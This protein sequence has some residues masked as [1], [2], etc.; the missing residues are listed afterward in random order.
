M[1]SIVIPALNEEH[2]IGA[3]IESLRK[4]LF[5]AGF[6][7]AEILVVDD[8]SSDQ[9]GAKAIE[10]GANVVRHPHNIG[11]GRALKRGIRAA[12]YDT[13]VMI[14]ADL[15]YPAQTIPA[16]LKEYER[17]FDMVVG[18]RTGQHYRE[19][20][21][22]APLRTFLKGLVEFTAGREV[23]DVNSGLRV[24]SKQSI[25]NHLDHLCDTFSFTTSLT[26]AY[27]LTGRFVCYINVPY[28]ARVGS[29]KVRLLRDSLRTLQYIVQ[30]IVYYNPIKI[31]LLLSMLCLTLCATGIAGNIVTHSEFCSFLAAGGLLFSVLMFGLGL[32]ADLL[33]QSNIAAGNSSTVSFEKETRKLHN[34]AP[35][36]KQ[37]RDNNNEHAQ[38]CLPTAGTA[39]EF[40]TPITT[41]RGT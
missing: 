31:F 2:A 35:A 39:A 13:I 24:F 30:A 21:L 7:D 10:A 12:K 15:T 4:V 9:T 19:S 3:T 8:G 23:P 22:K 40:N 5:E 18:A 17:G 38:N 34:F 29:T 41:G 32:L 20:A 14:D 27:M 33:R 16:L 6:Q 1:I 28:H 11:Y 26:L 37:S 25:S 36:E